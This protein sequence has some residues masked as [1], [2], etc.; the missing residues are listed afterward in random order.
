MASEPVRPADNRPRMCRRP[1]TTPIITPRLLIITII[2]PRH[3]RTLFPSSF[4]M[5][6]PR[7]GG[8][9]EFEEREYRGREGY[10]HREQGRE[11]FEH[12]GEGREHH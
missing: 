6:P 11:G 4:I 5:S 2:I 8:E 9:E 10:E 12:R 7:L 1:I 3:I